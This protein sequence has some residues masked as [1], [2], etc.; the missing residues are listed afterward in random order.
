MDEYESY[1]TQLKD[2]YAVYVVLFRN[3]SHLQ[4]QLW[5]VERAEKD[6]SMNADMEMR[7]MVERIRLENEAAP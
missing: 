5:D 6:R 2:L 4:R 7:S 3:L 1:E